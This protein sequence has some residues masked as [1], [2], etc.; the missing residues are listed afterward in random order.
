[1]NRTVSFLQSEKVHSFFRIFGVTTR[2]EGSI[3]Q[4]ASK[5]TKRLVGLCIRALPIIVGSS[6]LGF[7][8]ACFVFTRHTVRLV[9]RQ[10]LKGTAKYYKSCTLLLMKYCGNDRLV[11]TIKSGHCVSITR[12]GLPRIIPIQHRR[13]ISQGHGLVVR[14]WLSLFS[15]YRVLSFKGTP[16]ISTIITPGPVL[17]AEFL[18]DWDS[19]LE[20]FW[21]LIDSVTGYRALTSFSRG[22]PKVLSVRA[23]MWKA[24]WLLLLRGGPNSTYSTITGGPSCSVGNLFVDALAWVT[25]PELFALLQE[26]TRLTDND[27]WLLWSVPMRAVLDSKFILWNSRWISELVDTITGANHPLIKP[28]KGQKIG[29]LGR[30]AFLEEPGKWRVVA[31]LDYYTQ[32]LF[33][34]VHLEIFNKILKR[35]PQDGTFDQHAPI[36]KLQEYMKKKGITRVYSFDL[37]AATDRL[38]IVIQELVL[39]YLIGKPLA[40]LWVRL[41]TERLYSCPR[42]VD[43]VKTN[44]PKGGVQYAVGQPMGAYSSWAMLALTHHAIV[45]FAAWKCGMRTWFQHYAL[46]GDDVVICHR[47][48]AE[49]Y[50]GIMKVLGVEI[51]FAKS[52]SSDNGS[53]EFAKRFIFRGKDVSPTTLKHIA[54]GFSGIK[55]IPELVSSAM[56]VIDSVTLPRVLK[57]AGLGFKAQ[58]AAW[59]SPVTISKR[60][61]GLSLLLCSPHGPFSVGTLLDWIQMFTVKTARVVDPAVVPELFHRIFHTA[62][63]AMRVDL[64]TTMKSLETDL[65]YD[66]DLGL[67]K[68]SSEHASWF[69]FEILGL[70]RPIRAHYEAANRLVKKLWTLGGPGV[71]LSLVLSTVEE[72]FNEASLVPVSLFDTE[73][74]RSKGQAGIWIRLWMLIHVEIQSFMTKQQALIRRNGKSP[75]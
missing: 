16:T 37:S 19:F 55:F 69:K 66:S 65:T 43:G 67:L 38:P 48:I 61:L 35:I 11:A 2:G 52:L 53:F 75:G 4:S 64:E 10:G 15:I 26:W 33:H 51:S 25:R 3:W 68:D 39:S 56:K 1:M 30:L 5:D 71:D 45:Q 47:N 42:K 73:E 74:L 27:R 59:I 57:F 21:S 13:R 12:T 60:F 6:T 49:A 46:L 58:S 22:L 50:L 63:S 34:P 7:V 70:L 9:R 29:F 18:S 72:F 54:V 44:S 8:K 62:L 24:K 17:S 36:G 20:V 31:L 14:F 41:L 32:I 23:P 40:R 28:R